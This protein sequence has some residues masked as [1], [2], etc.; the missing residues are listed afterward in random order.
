RAGSHE[1]TADALDGIRVVP[2][3]PKPPPPIGD[4]SYVE[5][6]GCLTRGPRDMWT[7]TQASEPVVAVPNAPSSPD[8]AKPLGAGTLH[9]LDALA[10]AP[11]SHRGQKVYVRGLLIRL[12]GEQRMTISSLETIAPTCG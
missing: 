6:V 5:V 8:A 11:E 2:G 1:L 10:H 12:P 4:Y 7:L 9:L 3:Q